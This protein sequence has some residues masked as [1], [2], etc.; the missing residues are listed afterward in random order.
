MKHG[1]WRYAAGTTAVAALLLQAGCGGSED[2]TPPTVSLQAP[3]ATVSRTV[4]LQA[5][6]SDNIEVISVE[7]KV[8]GNSIGF[9]TTA[10][11]AID[12]NTGAV[13]DGSHTITAIGRDALNNEGTSA[14]VSVTVRNQ[15]PFAVTLSSREEN[16]VNASTA[17]GSG[18]LTVNLASGAVTGSVT[19]TGVT[20]TL[21][22]IHN[23][24]AGT[25]GPVLV[26]FTADAT[27][28]ARWGPVAGATLSTANV[29]ALLAGGLYVNV[30]SAA[31][32]GGE[33][34]G[35]ILPAGF[36]LY[37]TDLAGLQEVPAAATRNSGRAA[38]TLNTVTRVA[39]FHVNTTGL[40]DATASHLHRARAG[41]NGP[42]A[43]GFNKDAANASHWSA[44]NVTLA[45]A[46]F[47]ALQSA[48][49][50]VNVHTPA[51]AGGEVRGQVVP[52][53]YLVVVNR[54]DGEQE[55]PAPRVTT[56]R[57]TTALTVRTATGD[58]DVHINATGVDD[59]TL[60]HIHDGFAGLNGPVIVNMTK[61]PAAVTHWS[62]TGATL[63]AAQVA[64]L[65]DGG[66]YVNVHTPAAPAG[67]IRGQLL[68]EGA[69]LVISQ[70]T[71]RQEAPA[72]ASANGGRASVTVN[73][74]AKKL[75]VHVN[76]T[77]LTD[78]TLAH[79]HRGARGAAGPVAINLTK[80]A[81]GTRWSATAVTLTDD[82]LADYR[83]GN[84]YVNVHTP[85]NPGGEVR[86][87]VELPGVTPLLFPEIQARI[88]NASCALSGCH[89]DTAPP[90][91]MSLSATS[92]Y[93]A[94][95]G[96]ASVESP[97]LLRVD[98]GNAPGSYL[99]RKLEGGPSIVGARMPLVGAVIPQDLINGIRAWINAG[100]FGA[101]A[102]PGDTQ[103]PVVTLGSVPA[104]LTGTVTLTATATDNVGVSLVRWRVNGSVV[105]SDSTA[106][107]S[108]DWNSAS[109][110][111]GTVS[112]DA[113]ALDAAGNVG[114]STL[115]SGNVSNA[116]GA[117]AFTFTEIQTQVF[118]VSCAVSGCHAGASPAQG[119]SLAAP[120]YA[121]IVNV[122]SSESPSLK[123]ILPGD[124][125]NSYLVQKIEGTAAVGQ[126][127]PLGGPFLDA[128]TIARI[129]AWVNAGAP[130]N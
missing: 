125:A 59:A 130:N 57:G 3:A 62:A 20:A 82:Q 55:V 10:P 122:A 58:A 75:T 36:A 77:G 107:Y 60:A 38:I 92:S 79:I 43:V 7:F 103:A 24:F 11:Y 22:H 49:A 15:V 34:R 44:E 111:N 19:L 66:L 123:R 46:D 78:A 121:T 37:F 1:Y 120:A 129:R 50:Y 117:T 18:T 112:I 89:T 63:T 42:V 114:T 81:T 105:G 102:A 33:I 25:N 17:S 108:F 23:G 73:T 53:G 70:M 64:T 5:D 88:F 51:F 32:P 116:S 118:N 95:V 26:N 86:G 68:P 61:D 4:T 29:D 65:I 126:R 109:V 56:A 110:P 94:I 67:M 39:T 100:A 97:T 12:W 31:F 69:Q 113:Q 48:G 84:W 104:T 71:G 106:P 13:A 2:K 35:Q 101:A 74:V 9:D 90:L 91:G 14:A 85:A 98:P 41:T 28:P 54:V 83:A 47:D 72:V 16:P 40:T 45:Q 115:A 80:D 119:M 76:T 124:A 6:A 52:P 8:D 27:N 21:A 93:A 99:V 30:H 87:Q 96:Q 127:M 128:T